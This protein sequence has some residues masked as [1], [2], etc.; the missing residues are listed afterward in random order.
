[1]GLIPLTAPVI[2]LVKVG[3]VLVAKVQGMLLKRP[4]LRDMRRC[5][6]KGMFFEWPVLR[7]MRRCQ[8]KGMFFERSVLRDMG[9]CQ[10]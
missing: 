7:D 3:L 5:Q 10:I 6:I 1:M 4:V 8:I 2:A 9:R